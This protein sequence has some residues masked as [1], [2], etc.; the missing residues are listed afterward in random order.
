LRPEQ[1]PHS[2]HAFER[3]VSLP[4]YTRMTVSDVRRVAEA[5]KRALR[6]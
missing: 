4:M 6:A 5:A 2:Q 3:L 1:F